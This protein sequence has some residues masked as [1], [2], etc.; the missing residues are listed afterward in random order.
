MTL[1]G[2][3]LLHEGQFE[4]RKVR[5]P[6]FLRRRPDEACDEEL[7]NFYQ[8]LL[9]AVGKEPFRSGAWQLC[10]VEGWPDNRSCENLAAWCWKEG[11][12]RRLVVVNLSDAPAQGLLRVPW[13]EL[14]G[15]DWQLAE[16]L[17]TETFERN[18][19]EMRG[20]GIYIDLP[21]W[22]Y[23]LLECTPF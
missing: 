23:H 4:G 2:A 15:H 9:A 7:C 6:V 3:V 14:P 16:L 10:A 5:L 17:G 22:G 20:A 11:D 18:G 1:P 8:R 13:D 12:E 19:D 21:P